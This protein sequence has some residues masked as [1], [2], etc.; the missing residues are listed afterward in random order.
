M[1]KTICT[2][3][4]NQIKTEMKMFEK[5]RMGPCSHIFGSGSSH[6]LIPIQHLSA[7][8]SLENIPPGINDAQSK[9]RKIESSLWKISDFINIFTMAIFY[10]SRQMYAQNGP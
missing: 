3:L 8:Y 6:C 9:S 7:G 10:I 5:E 4:G 1:G 2:I